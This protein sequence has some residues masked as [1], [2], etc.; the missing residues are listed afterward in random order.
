MII[1]ADFSMT[2]LSHIY[3][4]TAFLKILRNIYGKPIVFYGEEHHLDLISKSF[5]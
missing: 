1:A 4:N 2:G 5:L 3:F